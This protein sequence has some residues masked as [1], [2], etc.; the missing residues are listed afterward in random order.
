MTVPL[1]WTVGTDD[2]AFA[3]LA[4]PWLDNVYR[5]ARS[6]TRDEAEVH[7]LVQETFRRAYR[8][9]DGFPVDGDARAWLFLICRQAFVTL[10]GNDVEPQEVL[11]RRA[12]ELLPQ[13]CR[14]ALMLEQLY[15]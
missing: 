13:R 8:Q 10:R 3:A 12:I 14:S 2:E 9:W 4:L 5:F 7:E 11:L 1:S 15:T 6:L